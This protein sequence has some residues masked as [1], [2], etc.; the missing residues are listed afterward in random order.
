MIR[1]RLSD[2]SSDKEHCDN[3][4]PISNETLKNS[5]FNE[6]LKFSP[7][8]PTRRHRGRNIIWFNTPFS[9]NVKIDKGKLFLN[10]L[11]N[12]FSWDHKYFKLFNKNNMKISYSC[13]RNMKSIILNHNVNLLSNHTTT[14]AACSC[15]CRQKLECLLNSKCLSE[16]LVYK[17]TISQTPS[18]INKCY[19]GTCE[20]TF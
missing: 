13:M 11:Q 4:A 9:S 15:S 6:T 1:K 16:S 10:L 19:Y 5:G 12:Y 3:A 14:V 2:I 20:K 8:I 17:A 7:P 18:E